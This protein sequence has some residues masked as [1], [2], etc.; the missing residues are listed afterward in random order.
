MNGDFLSIK[1]YFFDKKERYVSWSSVKGF[2]TS[3]YALDE[4]ERLKTLVL[5]N[6]KGHQYY[7]TF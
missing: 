7:P 6:Q 4:N 2:E 1:G 5:T 3:K